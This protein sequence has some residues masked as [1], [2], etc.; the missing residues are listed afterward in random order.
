MLNINNFKVKDIKSEPIYGVGET[1]NINIKRVIIPISLL[2]VKSF[3]LRLKIKYI[4]N[5]FHTLVLFSLPC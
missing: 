4:I 1:S 3:F 5:D 2:L